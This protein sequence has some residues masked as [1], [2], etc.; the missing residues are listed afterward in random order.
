MTV[1]R[2]FASQWLVSVALLLYLW[3]ALVAPDKA[4]QAL[5]TGGSLLLSVSLL[6]LAVMGLVGL[7][8]VWI[9]R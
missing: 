2:W 4:L 6:I 7:V 9:S 5:H 1:L 3:A 8:Q